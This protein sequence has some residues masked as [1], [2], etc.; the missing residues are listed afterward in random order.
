VWKG[1]EFTRCATIR[2]DVGVRGFL[3]LSSIP[4]VGGGVGEA[5]LSENDGNLKSG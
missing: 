5:K 1:R 4:D 2:V 3:K